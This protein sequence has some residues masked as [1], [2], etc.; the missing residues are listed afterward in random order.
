[1]APKLNL[2]PCTA[3]ICLLCLS[4]M[5]AWPPVPG[6]AEGTPLTVITTM[7]VAED[8]TI[9]ELDMRLAGFCLENV[10]TEPALSVVWTQE[11][12][13]GWFPTWE[14]GLEVAPHLIRP[15]EQAARPYRKGLGIM[16]PEAG[17]VYETSLSYDPQSGLVSAAVVD[18]TSGMRVF[19]V[20]TRL[21]A[22]S[23]TLRPCGGCEQPP[24]PTNDHT[25]PSIKDTSLLTFSQPQVV[26]TLVPVGTEWDILAWDAQTQ[27][28]AWPLGHS[29]SLLTIDRRQHREV[30]VQLVPP[31]Y[32]TTG[33]F[34]VTVDNGDGPQ[35]VAAI[36]STTDRQLLPVPTADFPVGRVQLALEYVDESRIWRLDARQIRVGALEM[37]MAPIAVHGDEWSGR[38][39]LTGDGAFPGLTLRLGLTLSPVSDHHSPRKGQDPLLAILETELAQSIEEAMT[40][41]FPI[42]HP[43]SD[44]RR[45]QLQF[46]PTLSKDVTLHF[47]GKEDVV[48]LTGRG[49]Y[50]P[51]EINVEVED[52]VYSYIPA[53]NG[54][55]PMW[56]RGS[57]SLVR[58]NDQLFAAGLETIPDAKP[59]NNCVPLLFYRDDEGWKQ[60]YRGTARTREPSPVTCFDDGRLFLSVNPTLTAPDTY[61]G[62]SEPR[63]LEFDAS[64]PSSGFKTHLPVW[65]SEPSFT[66]HSYRSFAAD[67]TNH[68]LILFQN[69]GYTHAEWAFYDR[70]GEWSAQGQLAWPWAKE[71]DE[72]GP[73][74][75]CYPTVALQDR[76][77]YFFGVSDVVEPYQVWRERKKE[78][79]G[80]AWDYDFRRIFFAWSDDIRSGQF[81]QWL[82]ISSRDSTAGWLT[83]CDLSVDTDGNVHLLWIERA[84][85]ERL[86]Q[87]F[88]PLERQTHTLN[89]AIVRDGVILLRR[90]LHLADEKH[91]DEV[92]TEARFHVAPSGRLFVFYLIR[93]STG[94]ENR[95]MEVFTDG[96]ASNPYVVPLRR[97][98]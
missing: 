47:T 29:A 36:C 33:R 71:Y 45:W 96:T 70:H 86:R 77:V 40:L 3:A 15:D 22:Y 6:H 94:L 83:P 23:G 11:K 76:A 87:E 34:R 91:P 61:N 25:G 1:M 92:P 81:H 51:P 2:F 66:E 82:E 49:R 10:P 50:T 8:T 84:L 60:V 85:D 26:E 59:L 65:V 95:I 46:E 30:A 58:C 44:H 98:R 55:G 78:I 97:H 17:H 57:T 27:S 43:T 38:L 35:E 68:E 19:S 18:L 75:I 37:T 13:G 79:T 32:P 21:Q 39:T 64:T 24:A 56:C 31:E 80:Q 52:E 67:A 20:S 69:I 62:P 42:P 63:L 9:P 88:Y 12:R 4:L 72:P 5:L 93:Y 7:T 28:F 48:L 41:A 14:V 16:G 89:Y 74:R 53:N 54:A 73:V 90:V